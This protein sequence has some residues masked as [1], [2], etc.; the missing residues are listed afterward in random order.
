MTVMDQAQGPFPIYSRWSVEQCRP[1]RDLLN[2]CCGN[3]QSTWTSRTLR[4]RWET[5]RPQMA[6]HG[7]PVP[8]GHG[9]LR[10]R[11]NTCRGA[12]WEDPKAGIYYLQKGMALAIYLGKGKHSLVLHKVCQLRTAHKSHISPCCALP[13]VI[14]LGSGVS[15]SLAPAEL[16]EGRERVKPEAFKDRVSV[17]LCTTALSFSRDR[18]LHN[19]NFRLYKY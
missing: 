19:I 18:A 16:P 1:Q 14:T 11:L 4:S 12:S 10:R 7:S 3:Q 5:K 8:G 17:L 2:Y 6:F 13:T 15:P 9:L